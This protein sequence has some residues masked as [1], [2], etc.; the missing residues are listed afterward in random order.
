MGY[1][2][3]RAHFA[4]ITGSVQRKKRSCQLSTLCGNTVGSNRLTKPVQPGMGLHGPVPS[5]SG[6][7][8]KGVGFTR[9]RAK[10]VDGQKGHLITKPRERDSV[11]VDPLWLSSLCNI[12]V[13]STTNGIQHLK[14]AH[15]MKRT[16][17]STFESKSMVT[18]VAAVQSYCSAKVIHCFLPPNNLPVASASPCWAALG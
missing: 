1:T 13:H 6:K 5:G 7:Q 2:C 16:H 18:V 12:Y 10:P 15:L 11:S 17:Q 14:W 4:Y 3:G 8:H 9:T